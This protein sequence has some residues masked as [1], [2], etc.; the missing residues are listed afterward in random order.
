MEHDLD[1][2]TARIETLERRSRRLTWGLVGA[3]AAGLALLAGSGLAASKGTVLEANAFVLRDADGGK[4]GEVLV[5]PD[6]GGRIVLYG[7]D[8]HAAAELPLTTQT[9]P[10]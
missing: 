8:G 5:G 4:R 1:A 9:F 10:L 6:G 7:A 2:L 3:G